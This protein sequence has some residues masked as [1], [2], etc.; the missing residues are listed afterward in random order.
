MPL[1]ATA[2]LKHYWTLVWMF[3]IFA[4][5]LSHG[6]GR[7]KRHLSLFFFLLTPAD[8]SRKSIWFLQQFPVRNGLRSLLV[9]LWGKKHGFEALL[10]WM[11]ALIVMKMN[12]KDVWGGS[13]WVMTQGIMQKEELGERVCVPSI[14]LQCSCFSYQNS[15]RVNKSWHSL[16]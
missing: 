11:L 9:W 7:L 14:W 3:L 6:R 5:S 16:D 10:L 2:I 15:M 13:S 4:C 12:S 8:L 1:L